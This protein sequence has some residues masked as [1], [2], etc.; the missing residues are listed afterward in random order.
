[1]KSRLASLDAEVSRLDTSLREALEKRDA[2]LQDLDGER[3]Q[4]LVSHLNTYLIPMEFDYIL[5]YSNATITPLPETDRARDEMRAYL[6]V[7]SLSNLPIIDVLDYIGEG[8]PY[9]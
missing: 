5:D 8:H 3:E 1:M 7:T 4:L 2:S 6:K 9:E